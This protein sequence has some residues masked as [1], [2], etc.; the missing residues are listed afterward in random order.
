MSQWSQQPIRGLLR[1]IWLMSI[2]DTC[3]RSQTSLENPYN[4]QTLKSS[5]HKTKLVYTWKHCNI[6][7]VL[8]VYGDSVTP[9]MFV[10]FRFCGVWRCGGQHVV[11]PPTRAVLMEQ[12]K[13]C[14]SSRVREESDWHEHVK[15]N[16]SSSMKPEFLAHIDYLGKWWPYT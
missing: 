7:H 8:C 10:C 1:L 11:Q 4:F 2:L 9:E 6:N 16:I 13:A 14:K 15:L 12:K 3:I 5:E